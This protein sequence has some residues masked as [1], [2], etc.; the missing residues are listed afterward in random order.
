MAGE[1][2]G[3][4]ACRP[5]DQLVLA[6]G[7]GTRPLGAARQ[8]VAQ[9]PAATAGH[10]PCFPSET[11]PPSAKALLAVDGVWMTPCARGHAAV[12]LP[13]PLATAGLVRCQRGPRARVRAGHPCHHTRGRWDHRPGGSSAP[14][15]A[16]LLDH[17][18]RRRGASQA[19]GAP[20]GAAAGTAG[21]RLLQRARRPRAA[22]P[23]RLCL[24]FL[25]CS[26]PQCTATP[27]PQP[28]DHRPE[29]LADAVAASASRHGRWADRPGVNEGC[30]APLSCATQGSRVLHDPCTR[31]RDTTGYLGFFQFLRNFRH[32]N[33]CEQAELIL[34]AALNRTIARRA[35]KGEFVRC[36]D[37]F[38]LLQTVR[39]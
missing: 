39:N 2:W 19:D 7:V 9:L 28:P 8:L 25:R 38:D 6:W 30:V 22:A 33:A 13:P 10:L 31:Y 16:G 24:L 36:L 37:H 27:A 29:R 4:I 23:P 21:D 18:H 34:Q 5:V 3:W 14:G 20:T 32:Q 15:V 11:L 17:Q 1:A 12:S 26:P 35:R